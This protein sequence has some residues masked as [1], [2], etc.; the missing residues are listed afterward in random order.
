MVVS[1]AL[2]RERAENKAY[3][4]KH[5]S[6]KLPKYFE[7]FYGFDS[8][9]CIFSAS[10]SAHAGSITGDLAANHQSSVDRGVVVPECESN[11]LGY[12]MSTA[13]S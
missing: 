1:A 13:A 2:P 4:N 8:S 6:K 5:P 9:D 7:L 3:C 12:G 11:H 10:K